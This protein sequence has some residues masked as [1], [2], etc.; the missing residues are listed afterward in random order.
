M[1][2]H[3]TFQIV[4]ALNYLLPLRALY[5]LARTSSPRPLSSSSFPKWLASRLRKSTVSSR[6]VSRRTDRSRITDRSV[7][8]TSR[9]R[10][11]SRLAVSR[12]WADEIR[13]TRRAIKIFLG[14]NICFIAISPSRRV[15]V[16]LLGCFLQ[17]AK[18]KCSVIGKEMDSHIYRP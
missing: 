1:Y 10:K 3:V 8:K 15:G 16:W 17:P 12:G 5:F 13:G 2:V 7:R 6:L 14:F 4:L 9:T 18:E 11:L